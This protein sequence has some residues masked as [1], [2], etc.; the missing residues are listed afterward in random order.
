MNRDLKGSA[1]VVERSGGIIDDDIGLCPVI[2]HGDEPNPGLPALAQGGGDVTEWESGLQ[3]LRSNEVR[4][5][6]LVA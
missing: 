3:G 2:G 6:V 1:C 5:D 4:R